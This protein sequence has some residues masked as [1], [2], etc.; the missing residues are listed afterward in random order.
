LTGIEAQWG[1][2]ASSKMRHDVV[3]GKEPLQIRQ[4]ASR[5]SSNLSI[6]FPLIQSSER[7]KHNPMRSLNGEV[8]EAAGAAQDAQSSMSNSKGQK[9][10]MPPQR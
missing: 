10:A 3:V 4:T 1:K 2:F 5:F 8:S 6:I 7:A 9:P